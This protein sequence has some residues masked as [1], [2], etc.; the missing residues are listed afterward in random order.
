MTPHDALILDRF[1]LSSATSFI[2]GG[3][4]FTG[5]S[6]DP[7]RAQLQCWMRRPIFILSV[8][9]ATA[10]IAAIPIQTAELGSGWASSVET[11]TVLAVLQTDL[12]ISIWVE[13]A[14]V[15][16]LLFA[17]AKNRTVAGVALAGLALAELA[18]RGHSASSFDA[19][20]LARMSMMAIHVLSAAAWVGALIPFI[21][22]LKLSIS[23]SLRAD[24][25]AAMTRFSRIG[26]V[27]VAL[28][29][30][31]G[32]GNVALILG[33]LPRNVSSPYGAGLLFKTAAVAAM[34][35]I[36]LANRYL[37]VPLANRHPGTASRLLIVGT[38]LEVCLGLLA[39]ALV[40]SFGLD[41]PTA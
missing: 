1:I 33:H 24:A 4:G 36:A 22:L 5:V 2:W 40:A 9:A 6:S 7:V 19:L 39:F 8:V 18:T 3:L 23:G 13:A 31:T 11:D 38:A 27:A 16:S 32:V 29:L 35:G 25:I 17:A 37:I 12:G 20:G 30:V 21:M 26:R 41:D 28:V 34:T 10:A 14:T 15:L